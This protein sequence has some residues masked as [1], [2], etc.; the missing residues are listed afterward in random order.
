MLFVMH[1]VQLTVRLRWRLKLIVMMSVSFCMM[2]S[3]L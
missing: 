3:Q 1:I 2:T